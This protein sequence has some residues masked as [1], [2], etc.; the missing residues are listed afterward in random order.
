M[1]ADAISSFF[2]HLTPKGMSV[3]VNHRSTSLHD[4]TEVHGELKNQ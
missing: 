4:T 3:W 1:K 2:N